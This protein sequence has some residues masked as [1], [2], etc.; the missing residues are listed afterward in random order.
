MIYFRRV[1]GDSM[2]PTL[3]DGQIVVVRHSRDS[4]VGDVV[5]A[6][7]G[8]REVV[9]RLSKKRAGKVFLEGDNTDNST[10][11]HTHGWLIDTH[12]TG[13]VVFPRNL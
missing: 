13:R 12:V 9:K 4:K 6:F 8:G 5:V 7:M 10:D 11:S 3:R 2:E 1:V